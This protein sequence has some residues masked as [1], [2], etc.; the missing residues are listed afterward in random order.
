MSFFFTAEL[1]LVSVSIRKMER[2]PLNTSEL[3]EGQPNF[4]GAVH[5]A[6][7]LKTIGTFIPL[8]T[9]YCI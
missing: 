4:D 3:V 9:L 2:L 6:T 7:T 8:I 5:I 1:L